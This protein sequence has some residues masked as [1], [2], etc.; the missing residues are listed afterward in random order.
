MKYWFDYPVF[1]N[2]LLCELA[3]VLCHSLHILFDI[4]VVIEAVSYNKRKRN[5]EN[6]MRIILKLFIIP[7]LFV[8]TLV[9]IIGN[10]ASN[11]LSYVVSFFLLIVVGCAI[12][13]ITKAMWQSLAILVVMAL[14]AFFAL[15]LSVWAVTVTESITE[16]LGN[17]IRA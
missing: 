8:L 4:V 15:F 5:G 3:V 12:F 7:L 16:K 6:N 13:C 14:A 2:S 10:L 1:N 9:K 11:A 17:Y